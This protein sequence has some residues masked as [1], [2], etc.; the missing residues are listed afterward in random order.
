MSAERNPRSLEILGAGVAGLALAWHFARL[1]G[2][3]DLWEAR[4]WVGGLARSVEHQDHRF[5]TGAHRIHAQDGTTLSFLREDLGLRLHPVR[6]PSRI[7]DRGEHFTFPPR[8]AEMVM[9][10]G[11]LAAP[12]ILADWVSAG[13]RYDAGDDLDS[14]LRRRFGRRLAERFLLPYSEKLWGQPPAELAVEA[15]TQRLAGVNPLRLLVEAVRLAAPSHMEG[16]FL[17]PERGIGQLAEALRTGLPSGRLH[18]R[19][20]LRR[21]ECRKGRITRL[22]FEDRPSREVA[23][24]VI[25]TIP[26]PA[27]VRALGEAL[28]SACHEAAAGL[29]YRA[30]RLVYIRLDQPQVSEH[31]TLYFPNPDLCFS[32]VSEPRNRSPHMAPPG[33]TGLL[34]EVPCSEGTPLHEA[35]DESLAARVEAQLRR[36]GLLGKGRLLSW[37][38]CRLPQAYPVPTLD[39][40]ARL[41]R[42]RAA[43]DGIQNLRCLGRT[44]CFAYEHLHHQLAAGRELA[45]KL[46]AVPA[47]PA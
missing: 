36:T 46:C 8:P 29:R 44:G 40:P 27:L 15:A 30:L 14:N 17:Y 2:T 10:R 28:P 37:T 32:R 11:L 4:S 38:H 16:G 9:S 47:E 35:D 18:L 21:L 19:H 45:Q 26:L 7:H 23:G 12:L 1:G 3:A 33:E 20:L 31:A 5:D 24:T 25:S 43:L 13:L 42:I 41:A 6:I 39:S 34:V 22:H